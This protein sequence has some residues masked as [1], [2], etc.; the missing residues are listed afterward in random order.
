MDADVFVHPCLWRP[1]ERVKGEAWGFAVNEAMAAGLPVI[2]TTAVAAAYDL[3]EDGVSG[4]VVAPGDH[5]AIAQRLITLFED[6]ALRERMAAMART[7]VQRYSPERQASI[8]C[9]AIDLL[10]SGRSMRARH[11][12]AETSE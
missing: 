10:W 3:I 4:Y 1:H 2:T 5:G 8:F 7:T 12:I 11:P 9:D 6:R